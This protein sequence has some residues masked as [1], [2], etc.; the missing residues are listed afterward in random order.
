M[1]RAVF[2]TAHLFGLVS[3]AESELLLRAALDDGLHRFD[4]AP[5]YGYG[6]SEPALG[7]LLSMR[8]A[9]GLT[10]APVV[11]TKTGIAP[12]APPSTAV[13]TV[14]AVARRLPAP[15]Q[16]RLRGATSGAAHGHFQP[17]EVR[18]SIDQSLQRL[19]RIDRL[20]LHEVSP[21]DITDELLTTVQD[22]LDRGDVRQLG[23][24]TAN[25]LTAACVAR[26][27]ALLVAAHVAVGPL[28]PPVTLPS[29]VLVRVGHGVLGPAAADLHR[30]AAVRDGNAALGERW[31]AAT[32]ST[33]WNGADGLAQALVARSATL[34]DEIIVAT[35]KRAR[36]P[37]LG[38]L[39]AGTFPVEPDVLS[40]LD[41]LIVGAA[42]ISAPGN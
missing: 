23:V 36:L 12:V 2:G 38:A 6:L 8:L 18:T 40:C 11:T 26:A 3:A 9:S 28:T 19:G 25:D 4:T 32:E 37:V 27:P 41:E 35:S 13:R 22:Y 29:T 42:A 1:A 15:V 17:G 34:A 16:H 39:V 20:M 24:A 14:K 21:D 10:P 7:R 33:R 31:Q 30:I 5:S